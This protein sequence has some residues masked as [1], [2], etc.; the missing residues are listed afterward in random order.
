MIQPC[1]YSE[2]VFGGAL[3]ITAS[4]DVNY[5][6]NFYLGAWM[7]VNNLTDAVIPYIGLDYGSFSLGMTYDVNVSA[8]KVATQGRGGLEISLIYLLKHAD[9][10][11]VQAVQCPRF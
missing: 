9:G 2:W 3:E 10:Q 11:S 7:R 8:F 5:P 6:V 1:F 4:A